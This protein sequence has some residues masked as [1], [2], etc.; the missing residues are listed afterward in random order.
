M[1]EL[2]WGCLLFG[3]LFAFLSVILG[4]FLSDMFDGMFD[5]LSL[6]GP[7]FFQPMVIVGFITGFGGAGIVLTDTTNIPQLFIVIL[8]LL[9][10][11]I[12]SILV[13]FTYV[14]PMQNAE[15]STGFT[16][17]DLVGRVGEV[18]IPL[19]ATGYG[20]VMLNIG[21]SNTNQ[22]AASFDEEDVPTGTRVVVV[23]IREE[24][25]YVSPINE[26]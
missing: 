22:I 8:S 15:A 10:A 25:L 13:Y 6:D 23:E 12:L 2:Y 7:Q 3:V 4:D 5:F 20:E 26:L 9:L 17:E 18:S 1:I 11:L 14:K 24:T 16:Y 21:S 19:P